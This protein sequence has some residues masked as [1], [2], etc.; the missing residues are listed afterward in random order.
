[1]V[2]LIYIDSVNSVSNLEGY[3]SDSRSNVSDS[4]RTSIS[5]NDVTYSMNDVSD[6]EGDIF[7]ST[8]NTSDSKC[9]LVFPV[10]N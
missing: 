7:N 1:M 8:A 6:I 5:A 4:S 2:T 9:N 10:S 3:V